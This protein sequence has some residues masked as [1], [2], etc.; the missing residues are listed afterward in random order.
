MLER[1]TD[2]RRHEL[3]AGGPLAIADLPITYIASSSTAS[4]GA[5]R[6]A[7][8][9]WAGGVHRSASV[10]DGHRGAAAAVRASLSVTRVPK[11]ADHRVDKEKPCDPFHPFDRPGSAGP[12][13]RVASSNGRRPRAVQ[14]SVRGGSAKRGRKLL[15]DEKIAVNDIPWRPH[16]TLRV[17]VH[18]FRAPRRPTPCRT[19][20]ESS[21]A[22]A[23]TATSGPWSS[24]STAGGAVSWCR[25]HVPR[26][27]RGSSTDEESPSSPAITEPGRIG[28]LLL[29][30]AADK[31]YAAPPRRWAA[32]GHRG[33][34]QSREARGEDRRRDPG[35]QSGAKEGHGRP[36]GA[37]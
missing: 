23:A 11:K 12:A 21:G 10:L 35:H 19:S 2:E 29:A 5:G 26:S 18:L 9:R 30:L 24:G 37:A 7:V 34:P 25:C 31:I 32:S 6:S 27:Q 4:K 33:L 36:V 22:R 14:G 15:D 13:E 28:W 16:E 17:F 20:K 8:T 1:A 3:G